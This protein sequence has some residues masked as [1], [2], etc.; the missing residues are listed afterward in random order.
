MNI[1]KITVEVNGK[2][3][4]EQ[5]QEIAKNTYDQIA[6]ICNERKADITDLLINDITELTAEEAEE[7]LMSWD[8]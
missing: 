5:H 6:R 3:I 8:M 2:K 1:I 4:S 7:I